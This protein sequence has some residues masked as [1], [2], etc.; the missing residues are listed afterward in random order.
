MIRPINALSLSDCPVIMGGVYHGP[1][2][3]DNSRI[4][5][6]GIAACI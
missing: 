1:G 3:G 2:G 6:V 5:A 4:A